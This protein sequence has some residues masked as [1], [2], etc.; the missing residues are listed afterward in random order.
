MS[1]RTVTD[2]LLREAPSLRA[3][4]TVAEAVRALLDSDL[5]ALPVID[6]KDRL[7]H[8]G[9]MPPDVV[10]VRRG[11]IVKQRACRVMALGCGVPISGDVEEGADIRMRQRGGDARHVAYRNGAFQQVRQPERNAADIG[12][13]GESKHRGDARADPE[14]RAD[15]Y[16]ALSG[17]GEHEHHETQEHAKS[18][19]TDVVPR[20]RR[21]GRRQPRGHPERTK[22]GG[23]R[24]EQ[25]QVARS[26]HRRPLSYASAR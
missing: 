7:L 11:A 9:Q 6:E 22:P 5:P 23:H 1:P 3:S 24:S 19:P 14:R 8:R 18:R 10:E 13:L 16:P 21:E 25:H 15:G 26:E 20:L 12:G 2:P 17:P 4:D